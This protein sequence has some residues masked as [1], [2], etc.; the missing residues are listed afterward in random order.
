MPDVNVIRVGDWPHF[1]RLAITTRAERPTC[2]ACSGPLWL[3]DRVEAELVDL[4]CFGHRTRLIWSK[5][6]WRCPNAVCG[7]ATFVEVDDC[8]A[9][10]CAG[11]TDWA[12]RWATFQVGPYGP[13]VSEVARAATGAR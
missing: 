13:A 1:L 12:G 6:C 3:H 4:P 5:Q 9:D 7:V 8:I 11:I 10:Q 2:P